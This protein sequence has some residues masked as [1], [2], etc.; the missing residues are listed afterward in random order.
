MIIIVQTA[1]KTVPEIR[2]ILWTLICVAIAINP[3]VWVHIDKERREVAVNTDDD[4]IRPGQLAYGQ[5]DYADTGVSLYQG[6]DYAEVV[7][8]LGLV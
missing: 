3:R 5:D 6:I 2:Q 1:G 7:E 8:E 4:P